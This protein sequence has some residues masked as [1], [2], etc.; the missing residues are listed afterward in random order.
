MFHILKKMIRIS[1]FTCINYIS[2]N[3]AEG[4]LIR[5]IKSV[6]NGGIIIWLNNIF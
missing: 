6:S 3:T 4:L 5:Q 2:Q 1:I